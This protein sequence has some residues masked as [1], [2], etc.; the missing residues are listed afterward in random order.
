[1]RDFVILH[2]HLTRGRSEPLWRQCQA[3]PIPETLAYRI[4]QFRHSGRIM[5]SPD[6]LF[7]DASRLAVLTGQGVRAEDYNPL[8]DT[9][10]DADNAAQLASV[11]RAIRD[12]AAKLPAIGALRTAR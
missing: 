8:L 7:R 5:L 12:T 9:M 3:M 6:E 1:M 4:D 10:G 2:Y 11:R